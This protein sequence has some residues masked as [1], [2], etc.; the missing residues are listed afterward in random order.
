MIPDK[1][2]R[3]ANLM[4]VAVAFLFPNSLPAQVP[5]QSSISKQSEKLQ[6]ADGKSGIVLDKI[7]E[8]ANYRLTVLSSEQV[9]Q[10][11]LTQSITKN[12]GFLSAKWQE[13]G[14]K[15]ALPQSYID[16]LKGD[17]ELLNVVSSAD[18]PDALKTRI[19]QDVADDLDVKSAHW[20]ASA[21]NWATL[22]HVSV[23]TLKDGKVV[24]NHEVWYVP[25]GWAD[26]DSQWIRCSKL[27][28]PAE[29]DL[30]PG[31]YML[32]IDDAAG[33]PFKIG[34]DGKDQQTVELRVQ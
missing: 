24:G 22:V 5:A 26:V 17:Q 30:P 31:V 12:S 16:Q 7:H 11:A 3:I 15:R 33:S 28:S 9:R 20:K 21:A 1:A 19:L 4:T 23:N 13:D 14:G 8:A 29:A 2:K 25:R 34:G 18:T 10:A 32:R 6:L 27:S